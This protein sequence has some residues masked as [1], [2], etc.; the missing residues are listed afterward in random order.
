MKAIEIVELIKQENPKV[1]GKTP[2]EKTAK[3]ISAALRQ[4]SKQLDQ[5]TEGNVK[6]PGLG[7]FSI[8]QVER[9]KEGQT[10]AIKKISFRAAKLKAKAKKTAEN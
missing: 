4:I 1:L 6:I 3:I 7:A 9:E 5:A 10:V 2:D 8:R